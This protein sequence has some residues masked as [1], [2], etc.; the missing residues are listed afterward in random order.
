MFD[1]LDVRR[2][3]VDSGVSFVLDLST[4]LLISFRVRRSDLLWA[5]E[6]MEDGVDGFE[7]IERRSNSPPRRVRFGESGGLFSVGS[8]GSSI[9]INC[10]GF[11]GR[12]RFR[13][14]SGCGAGTWRSI[15]VTMC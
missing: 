4:R 1:A 13:A 10:G 7:L 14:S 11:F 9:R 3:S 6:R 2:L 12:P 15:V 5:S 8:A